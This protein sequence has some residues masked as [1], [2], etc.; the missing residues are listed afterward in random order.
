MLKK[1][2]KKEKKNFFLKAGKKLTSMLMALQG[3]KLKKVLTK[4]KFLDTLQS[5]AKT[6]ENRYQVDYRNI[7]YDSNGFIYMGTCK[8]SRFKRKNFRN[9]SGTVYY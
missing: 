1:L 8:R 7:K 9:T 3:I 5:K 2:K 4:I 6:Y